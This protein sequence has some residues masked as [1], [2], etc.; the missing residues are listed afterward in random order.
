MAN[1]VKATL[2][3]VTRDS[4]STRKDLRLVVDLMMDVVVEMVLWCHG[5]DAGIGRIE[6]AAAP[7]A[8]T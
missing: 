1:A 8:P 3:R 2:A 6:S 5:N 7:A 4:A